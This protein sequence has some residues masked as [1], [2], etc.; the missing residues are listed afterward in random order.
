MRKYAC[1]SCNRKVAISWFRAHVDL[2]PR[3]LRSRRSMVVEQNDQAARRSLPGAG[4]SQADL[5]GSEPAPWLA[6]ADDGTVGVD[7]DMVREFFL[8]DAFAQTIAAEIGSA[9]SPSV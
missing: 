4:Q 9:G 1:C 8:Q 6:P 5:I 3:R 7:P 2:C